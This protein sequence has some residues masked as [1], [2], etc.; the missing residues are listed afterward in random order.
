MQ[1][2]KGMVG[3]KPTLNIVCYVFGFLNYILWFTKQGM[4]NRPFVF[5][6]ILIKDKPTY[7]LFI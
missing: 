1:K 6:I 3:F 5:F 2:P 7:L 4:G